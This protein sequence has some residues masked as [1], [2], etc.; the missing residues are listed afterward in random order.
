M[1]ANSRQPLETSQTNWT[2][3]YYTVLCL[4][5]V[6]IPLLTALAML[7]IHVALRRVAN[8]GMDLPD[9]ALLYL[10][11]GESAVAAISAVAGLAILPLALARR[12]LASTIIAGLILTATVL[13][14]TAAQIASIAALAPLLGP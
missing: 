12:H 1:D 6:I 9:I 3:A 4:S 13:F 2:R 5:L 10:R 8:A 11:I 14:T 7:T